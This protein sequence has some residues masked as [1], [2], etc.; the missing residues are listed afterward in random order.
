MKTIETIEVSWTAQP[1][2]YLNQTSKSEHLYQVD[3]I[4]LDRK[5]ICMPQVVFLEQ[6]LD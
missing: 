5:L 1:A 3:N 2:E 4:Y 6:V